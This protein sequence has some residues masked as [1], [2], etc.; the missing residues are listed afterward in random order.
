MRPLAGRFIED[1]FAA[2]PVTELC[3]DSSAL[4]D[5]VVPLLWATNALTRWRSVAPVAAVVRTSSARLTTPF[6]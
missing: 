1:I 6:G 5:T 2:A 4:S 3:S